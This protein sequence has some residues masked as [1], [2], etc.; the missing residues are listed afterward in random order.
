MTLKFQEIPIHALLIEDSRYFFPSSMRKNESLARV[1]P[2]LVHEWD[3]FHLIKDFDLAVA[4]AGAKQ[5][6]NISCRILP[7]D[8]PLLEILK[9]IFQEEC[10]RQ[11]SVVRR[12]RFIGLAQNLDL[13]KDALISELLPVAGFQA[14][15]V[16]YRRME[17]VLK[18]PS[19]LLDYC[20][21]KNLSLK[22]C[23]QFARFAPELVQE[24]FS[25]QSALFLSVSLFEEVLT[26]IQEWL[27]REGILIADFLVDSNFK[28]IIHSAIRPAEKTEKIRELV[29][30]RCFPLLT[31][32]NQKIQAQTEMLQNIPVLQC[33]WDKTLEKREVELRLRIKRIEEWDTA[34]SGL[35]APGTRQALSAILEELSGGSL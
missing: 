22:Q 10:R 15:E 11:A 29:R 27:D 26:S 31:R 6:Q 21:E 30:T 12:I 17:A 8:F 3:G 34:L 5:G 7:K 13:P 32:I 2:L 18:L 1:Q 16:L 20:E 19:D 4:L 25:W 14:H 35:K 24:V 33:H 9:I 23:H 28:E